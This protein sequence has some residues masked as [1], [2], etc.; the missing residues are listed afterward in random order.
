MNLKS[1]GPILIAAVVT[2]FPCPVVRAQDTPPSDRHC[3]VNHYGDGLEGFS[4]TRDQKLPATASN[5]VDPGQNGSVMIHG[6]NQPDVLVRACIQAGAAS[7]AEARSLISAVKIA[8]GAGDIQP[9]GPVQDERHRWDVSYEVWMPM[10]SNVDAAAH[11]GSIA[12]DSVHGQVRFE[13]VNGSVHLN[14]VGGDV[15]G[16]TT[17]GSVNVVLDGAAWQ[18]RG[19]R[20]E[21]TNG[22]VRLSLPENYSAKIEASTVNG[23]IHVDFPITVSGEIGRSLSF[24][25]GSGGPAIQL[26]TTNGSVSVGR[27]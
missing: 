4:E 20:A 16:S 22:S 14:K 10:Q 2:A 25:L 9:D 15:N 19:L 12:I 18:G 13:T 7:E 17:N 11:N 21:T 24:Q 1:L 3:S 6:W 8:R 27:S 26:R 5:R 23:R